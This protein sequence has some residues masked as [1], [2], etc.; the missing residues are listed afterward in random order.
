MKQRRSAGLNREL[1]RASLTCR[2]RRAGWRPSHR[3]RGRQEPLRHREDPACLGRSARY[4]RESRSNR[5]KVRQAPASQVIGA[6]IKVEGVGINRDRP[7][8]VCCHGGDE[9][10]APSERTG[11]RICACMVTRLSWACPRGED[12]FLSAAIVREPNPPTKFSAITSIP[13][14][15]PETWRRE[16]PSPCSDCPRRPAHLEALGIEFLNHAQP[17]VRLS[18]PRRCAA[19]TANTSPASTK[20]TRNLQG[21]REETIGFGVRA[22]GQHLPKKIGPPYD[23]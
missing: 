6:V 21:R 15:L 14:S 1:M 19:E 22:L 20:A 18:V 12:G 5:P 9:S 3:M 7:L 2:Q 8:R 17:G 4:R 13:G 10:S 23:A 11:G 16:A